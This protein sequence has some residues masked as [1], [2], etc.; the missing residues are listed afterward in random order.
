M[1]KKQDRDLDYQVTVKLNKEAFDEVKKASEMF[2]GNTSESIRFIIKDR[3]EAIKRNF[4]LSSKLDE[5]S[6]AKE[7]LSIRLNKLTIKSEFLLFFAITSTL[8]AVLVIIFAVLREVT[9]LS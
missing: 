3:R 9:M 4:S 1:T 5:L 8:A 2:N 6:D 7:W